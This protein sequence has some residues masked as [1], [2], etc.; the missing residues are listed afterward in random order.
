LMEL[1]RVEEAYIEFRKGQQLRQAN[2]DRYP[3]SPDWLNNLAGSFY[4]VQW[5][6]LY[7]G[8][9]DKALEN[10]IIS[11]EGYKKLAADYPL[12]QRAR[13]NYAR[14][15]RWR[16]EAEIANG[17]YDKASKHLR[18]SVAIHRELLDFEPNEKTFQYQ[19]CVSSVILTE[20]LIVSRK[21]D[22]AR[23]VIANVCRNAPEVLSLNHPVAHNRFYG[24]RRELVRIKLEMLEGCDGLAVKD[25]VKLTS[26]FEQET[27][28]IKNSLL[29]RHVALSLAINAVELN[30]RM[31]NMPGAKLELSNLAEKIGSEF[32]ASHS[33]TARLLSRAKQLSTDAPDALETGGL[34]IDF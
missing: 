34:S 17:Q 7:L 26:Q 19:A 30:N 2:V 13:G 1:G 18:Q 3:G 5:A 8:E 21:F 31:Q 25:Y 22:D 32:G 12:D 33:P 6:E 14:S 10:A 29:G 11:Y 20:V 23:S 15:L 9:N 16:S 27:A 4:H 28:E 24:Y